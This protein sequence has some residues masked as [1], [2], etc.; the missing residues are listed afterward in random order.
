MDNMVFS[1]STSH[2]LEKGY[3]VDT[4][5]HNGHELVFYDRGCS[6]IVTINGVE[7]RITAGDVSFCKKG[8]S[9]SEKHFS[10]VECHFFQFDCDCDIA[11]GVYHDVW[12]IKPIILGIIKESIN[13]DYE[14]ENIIK[15]KIREILCLLKRNSYTFDSKKPKTLFYCKNYI[16]ENYMQKLSIDALAKMTGYSTDHFRLLFTQNFGTSP[17]NYIIQKRCENAVKY[18]TETSYKCIDIAYKC[19]FSDSGQMTKMLK[20]IYQKTPQQIRKEKNEWN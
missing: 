16:N 17:Y 3:V 13:Q 15:L 6:G 2:K 20:K 9:H 4:Q 11:D 18:L 10:D 14:Y 7:H 8:V 1:F 5:A 12:D 19:G